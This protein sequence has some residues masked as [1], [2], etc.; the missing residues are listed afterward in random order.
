MGRCCAFLKKNR[1]TTAVH[2]P[3]ARLLARL[4]SQALGGAVQSSHRGLEWCRFRERNSFIIS[5]KATSAF[6]ERG[7]CRRPLRF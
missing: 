4:T 1:T 6:L 3:N 5:L 7:G 2:I